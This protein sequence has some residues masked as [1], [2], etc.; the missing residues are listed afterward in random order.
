MATLLPMGR[1]PRFD[2]PSDK[3]LRIRL[4][5]EQ[6]AALDAVAQRVQ[7]PTSDWARLVLFNVAGVPIRT[8]GRILP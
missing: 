2:K 7:R 1:K 4:T 6:M 3:T 5:P 8:S